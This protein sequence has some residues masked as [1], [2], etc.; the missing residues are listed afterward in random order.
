MAKVFPP[1]RSFS[2]KNKKFMLCTQAEVAGRPYDALD[3]P[4]KRRINFDSAIPPAFYPARWFDAACAAQVSALIWRLMHWRMPVGSRLQ[5]RV[6]ER[7][8]IARELHDTL[9]QGA[10]GL[11]ITV[12]NSVIKLAKD[13]PVRSS[14][15][16]ALDAA[17]QLLKEAR[18]RVVQLRAA[19]YQGDLVTAIG[20]SGREVFAGAL[21]RLSVS[22]KGKV[23]V[24]QA[25]VA[26]ELY[27]IAREALSNVRQ[28]AGATIVEVEM[29]FAREYLR[30]Y[31]RD[32][33]IGIAA[34][35]I[36]R[37]AG[38]AHLGII[39]M[40][41]RADLI[42]AR[43]KMF[44]R[45]GAGVEIEVAVPAV[46]AYVRATP[47]WRRALSWQRPIVSLSSGRTPQ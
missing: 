11:M 45:G 2:Y 33:G 26:E 36:A 7:E 37:G 43:F 9:I 19:Q 1:Y 20:N 25:F 12:Q 3:V 23:Q 30:L 32:N 13:D 18:Q 39:G 8:R 35:A 38:P 14:M 6:K 31:I 5:E 46:A 16:K 42:G 24:L 34:E 47:R 27:W 44:S 29:V 4:R 40:R 10:L 21:E 17:D 41:E 28:H 15:E 22:C